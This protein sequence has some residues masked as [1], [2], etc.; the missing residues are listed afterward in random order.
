MIVFCIMRW[1]DHCY[2]LPMYPDLAYP[3]Q[4]IRLLNT[5]VTHVLLIGILY[6]AASADVTSKDTK[7]IPLPT[8]YFAST[9]PRGDDVSLKSYV[10]AD[11]ANCID[12]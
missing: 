7:D 1:L 2:G 12:D 6:S 4:S 10:D 3:L 11:F 9:T 5:V 8:A